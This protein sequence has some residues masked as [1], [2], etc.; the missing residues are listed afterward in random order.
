M[1]TAVS[2]VALVG[3]ALSRQVAAGEIAQSQAG[4]VRAEQAS[5]VRG[6]VALLSGDKGTVLEQKAGVPTAFVQPGKGRER[7]RFDIRRTGTELLV[8]PQDA[9]ADVG[10]GK[11]DRHLFDVKLLL[12]NGYDDA[13]RG[14]L[15]LIVQ[16][17]GARAEALGSAGMTVGHRLH[18]V[19]ALLMF[20]VPCRSRFVAHRRRS[21]CLVR[22]GNYLEV[23]VL[24]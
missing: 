22:P 1:V 2:T 19:D 24:T 3:G 15:P 12:E 11:L 7:V 10:S 20:E 8:V 5:G 23:A 16:G 4:G 18:A 17:A 6:Q 13:R 21:T 9:V 14:D